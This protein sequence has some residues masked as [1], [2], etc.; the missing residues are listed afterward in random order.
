MSMILLDEYSTTQGGA[1]EKE[2]NRIPCC[3][4]STIGASANRDVGGCM[5]GALAAP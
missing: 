2:L 5:N 3:R 1:N 4:L